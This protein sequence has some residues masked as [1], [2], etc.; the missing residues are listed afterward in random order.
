M[1]QEYINSFIES[2]QSVIA[3]V[4]GL[5]STVGDI[6]VKDIP[7]RSDVV[8]VLIGLTGQIY[9]SVIISLSKDLA[10][11]IASIM[12]GGMEVTQLDEISK[13]AIAE[14]GNMIMGNTA[15][16]LYQKIRK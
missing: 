12:M 1:K 9:G 6:E 8:V 2:S 3:Q 15:N 16:S 7:Y 13:S 14:L 4:T 10:C 11:K 5:Q